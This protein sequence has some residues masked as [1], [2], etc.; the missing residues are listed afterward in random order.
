MHSKSFMEK[1]LPGPMWSH[2]GEH[3][4]Y[5]VFIGDVPGRFR[6]A[7]SFARDHR[8]DKDRFSSLCDFNF[9]RRGSHD[10]DRQS[11]AVAT[12]RD[13]RDADDFFDQMAEWEWTIYNAHNGTRHK[14]YA[15]VHY[16]RWIYVSG[17]CNKY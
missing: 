9:K 6:D 3:H 1:N 5:K 14:A 12:F 2:Q 16:V 10:Y 11:Y 8:V 4:G 15:S 17:Y 7:D 13:A